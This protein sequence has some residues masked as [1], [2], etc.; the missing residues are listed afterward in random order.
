MREEPRARPRAGA[1]SPAAPVTAA[2]VTTAPV[3]TSPAAAELADAAPAT[4][5][6]LP[7]DLNRV[8]EHWDAIVDGVERDGRA[9]LAAALRHATP[10][11]VTAAGVVTLTVDAAAQTDLI[12]Q[13]EAAI[14]TALR[15]RFSTAAKLKV[16]AAGA[17]DA[18]PR[19]LNE[20]EVRSDR[21]A[22]LRKQSKLLDAAVEALDLE[23]LD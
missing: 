20:Q 9:V 17:E 19:R 22:M 4:P 13:G 16:H 12:V 10:T 15:R 5:T 2:P 23:L 14:L 21:I 1:A 7:L 18:P 8:A 3:T 11:A 6:S